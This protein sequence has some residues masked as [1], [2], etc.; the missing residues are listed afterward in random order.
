MQQPASI[1]TQWPTFYSTVIERRPTQSLQAATRN[2]RTHT[3][4]QIRKIADSIVEFGFTN[5][6]LI[7]ANG[8]VIAGH[9]RLEAAKRLGL[10]EVP[11]ISLEHLS[12]AQRR[13]YVIADNRLAEQAGWDDELLALELGELTSLNFDVELTG[14]D[15]AEI[16]RLLS[17]GS[18][19]DEDLVDADLSVVE[20][21]RPGDVW[22]LGDHRLYCG[23]ATA[24]SSYAQALGGAAAQ[25]VFTDPPYNVPIEGHVSGSGRHAEFAMASGEMSPEQFTVF[26]E[27][28][29]RQLVACTANGSIHFVCMD[30]RHMAE[31]CAASKPH[32]EL[33]N[34]CVWN[35]DN[36]GMGS[37][38]RSKH[39][40]IFVF[41]QG[42]A[43]H[44][45]NIQLGKHG[46]YRTNVWDYAGANSMGKGRAE[47]LALHP[48]VKPVA[49][50]ADAIKD[51]SDR[52][53]WILDPFGGSGSTLVAAHTTGRRAAL[54][55]LAPRYVDA[56]V[57][58]FERLTQVAA[59]HLESG[60]SFAELASLRREAAA[61]E[62]PQ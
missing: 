36:G 18:H 33:K 20:I 55:E 7:D 35:K 8:T 29:F 32:Y 51:C 6:L 47:R 17:D 2:P 24:P 56:T 52:S 15:T 40:L 38:Y 42:S 12:E 25:M 59:R 9:A 27:T 13:A 39:E 49:L 43:P 16:D 19:D 60:L 48:T 11:T 26:L 46:R 44:I 4:K 50:I 21:S 28:I 54:I 53:A 22:L 62:A 3:P 57:R 14:F 58:R 41:K 31:M 1:Q 10:P 37:L 30:W 34:L 45:N 61:V 23:D 5:P